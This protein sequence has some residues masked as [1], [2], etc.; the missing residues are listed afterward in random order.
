MN[1]RERNRLLLVLF[2]GVLMGAL[3]I[4]IVGPALPG[5]QR[6]FGVG[7]DAISWVFTIYVLFN[8]ISTPLMAKLSDRFGR[9]AIYTLDVAL[10]G[11]GSLIVAASPG[12]AALLLGRAVQAVGAGGI[13]P[14]ASAV[15]GDTF[16]EEKR[17]RALGIIGAVFGLAFLA[18]PVLGGVFLQFNWHWLFLVNL[19]IAAGLIVASQRLVP[20]ARAASTAPFDWSGVVVLSTLLAGLALGLS[21]IDA[22]ALGAS[23]TSVSVGPLLLLA[24][25]LAPVFWWLERRAPDAVLRPSLLASSQVRLVGLVAIGAGLSEA[26]MV[27][28]PSLAVSALGVSAATASFMLLPLVVALAFGSPTAGRLLETVGSKAVVL[29]GLVLAAA[30]LFTLGRHAASM[31]GF[32]T[33]SIL[34]G[35]GLSALLGAPLRYILLREA[36]EADRGASQGLLTMFTSVGQLVGGALVGAVAASAAAGFPGALVVLAVVMAVLVAPSLGFK[37]RGRERAERA[38]SAETAV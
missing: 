2:V 32:I 21:R 8:L 24:L 28:L 12:F 3:D 10:F 26:A 1:D 17:G 25:A 20:S 36:G 29:G 18:G 37:G 22:S 27:F 9:R 16:P 35:L 6:S 34:V 11:A 15:I 13:F 7:N 38:E 30:G 4:A 14:V 31:G 23:L 19:P 33:G 5:I